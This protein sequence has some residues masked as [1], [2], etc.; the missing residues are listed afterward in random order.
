MQL[1]VKMVRG[2]ADHLGRVGSFAEAE[3]AC[4]ACLVARR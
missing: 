4:G 3:R 1:D 2:A